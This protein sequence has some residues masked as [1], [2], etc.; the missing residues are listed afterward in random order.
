[1]ILAD[2]QFSRAFHFGVCLENFLCY[3]R[4]EPEVPLAR[5]GVPRRA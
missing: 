2:N 5:A 1:M 4:R 3:R